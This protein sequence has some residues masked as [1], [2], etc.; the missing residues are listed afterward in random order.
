M[1]YAAL[2]N[3]EPIKTSLISDLFPS[4]LGNLPYVLHPMQRNG[5]PAFTE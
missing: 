2:H 3:I 1:I 4:L 5:C